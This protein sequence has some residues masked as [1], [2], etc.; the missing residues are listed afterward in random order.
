MSS[1]SYLP[2]FFFSVL[3]LLHGFLFSLKAL[4][5]T[6]TVDEL[7]YMKEQ[8]ALLEPNKNGT[9]S[10]DNI[11]AVSFLQNNVVVFSRNLVF[12]HISKFLEFFRPW[13]EMQLMP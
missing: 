8:F 11:K 4:S 1:I 9:I 2:F 10:L 12:I 3:Y 6:L 7:H 13:R 5:K